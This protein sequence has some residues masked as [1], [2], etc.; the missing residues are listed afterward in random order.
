MN[1]EESIKIA[2]EGCGVNLY[3]IVTT[4][5]H[6]NNIF[7]IYITCPQGI[8]LDKCAEVSRMVS[9]LLDINEP[10]NGKYNLEISSPGIERKLKTLNHFQCSIGSNIKI[11]E[12]STETLKGELIE[13]TQDG[14]IT[15]KDQD[16][17]I[18]TLKFDDILSA[19][20]YFE[21]KN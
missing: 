14:T 16:D 10:M 5:E 15:I 21:W 9:P 20:T 11:K 4:K 18:Q 13:V 1:L 6:H 2:V 17:E 3:D 12:Y 7:R 8:S 19:S